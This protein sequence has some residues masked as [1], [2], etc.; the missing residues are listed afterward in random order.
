VLF[1]D[2]NLILC[3]NPK[4]N[5]PTSVGDFTKRLRLGHAF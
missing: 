1:K 4:S 2:A 5:Q 3:Q